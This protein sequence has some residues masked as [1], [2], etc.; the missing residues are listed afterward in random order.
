[1][2]FNSEWYDNRAFNY[3]NKLIEQIAELFNQLITAISTIIP[4]YK[5]NPN[6]PFLFSHYPALNNEVSVLLNDFRGNITKVIDNGSLYVWTLANA[7]NDRLLDYLHK[8]TGIDKSILNERYQY[9]V[10]NNEALEFFQK[11]KIN[12]KTISRRVW[13]I[14]NDTKKGIQLAIGDNITSGSSAAS[15][16]RQ[17]RNYLINPT[18][19][20]KGVKVGQGVYR[21]PSKNANRLARTEINM[22]YRESDYQRWNDLD[23]VVGVEIRLSNNPKHCLLCARLAGKYPKNFKWRGWHPQ[24]R[25]LLI[26][27]LMSKVDFA[28][29]LS[30]Q[31]VSSKSEVKELP[32]DFKDWHSDNKD[33]IDKM[34]SMPYFIQDNKKML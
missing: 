26:P 20:P 10:R 25:C 12:G 6:K 32:K 5:I 30:G 15:L 16:S 14:T 4:N 27:I 21:S 17:I 9:G 33:K 31:D 8:S 19:V 11:R 29:L 24:C 2:K 22:S 3:E 18:K 13:E 7:K 34:K 23:F 28:K 1:M